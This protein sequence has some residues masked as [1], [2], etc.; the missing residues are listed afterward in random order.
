MLVQYYTCILN[1]KIDKIPDDLVLYNTIFVLSEF[2]DSLTVYK[3]LM[4][5]C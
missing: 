3:P 5:P 2:F 1:I 4:T